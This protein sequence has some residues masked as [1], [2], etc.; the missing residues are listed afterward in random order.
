MQ[1]GKDGAAYLAAQAGVPI[2][3]VGI[4][5]SDNLFAEVRRLRWPVITLRIGR[6]FV[7][8]EL[9]RRARGPDLTAY[10]NLIMAHIAV[11]VEPRHRGLYA[12]SPAVTGLLA[13]ADPWPYC[14]ATLDSPASPHEAPPIEPSL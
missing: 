9:G 2:L 6:P 8:P 1:P 4:S 10:T 11:L 7:L 13:G 12:D 5:N 14:A 3:P